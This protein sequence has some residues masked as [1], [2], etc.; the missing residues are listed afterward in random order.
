MAGKQKGQ[1]S[2]KA[3]S[4]KHCN[5]HPIIPLFTVMR[6]KPQFSAVLQIF[7]SAEGCGCLAKGCGRFTF[8]C[9]QYGSFAVFAVVY[10]YNR[11]EPRL[12]RI[13]GKAV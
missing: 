12:E 9:G 4:L 10:S 6:F 5:N 1:L 11:R 13:S 2:I 7:L 8:D 3:G